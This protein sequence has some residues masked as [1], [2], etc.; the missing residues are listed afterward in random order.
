MKLMKWLKDMIFWKKSIKNPNISCPLEIMDITSRELSRTVQETSEV[1]RKLVKKLEDIEDQLEDREQLLDRMFHTIPDFLLLKDGKGHWL[2]LNAYGKKLYGITGRAYKG[3][4]DREIAETLSPRYKE[5]LLQCLKTDE[6]AWA[7]RKPTE[8]E[9]KSVDVFGREYIFDVV[10]TPLFNEDGSRKY[11]LV[12][13]RNITEEVNN[14]KH[15]GMLIRALDH[16][17]DSIVVTDH[18]HRIVYANKAFL[19]V[20]GYEL[21]DIL[22]KPASICASGDT[23]PLTFQ[24]MNDT[25]IRGDPWTGVVYNKRAN[26]RVVQ[27]LLTITPVL[28]GKPHPIYYIGVKR[29]IERRKVD[30]T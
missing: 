13:G 14:D 2:M 3:K 9:E 10:K 29:L 20:Y 4:S 21:E 8:F 6:E 7:N 15:I 28:N 30:R 1:S 26:G 19:K 16:A 27:E 5:N 22:M 25:I 12:H 11:L 17:S 23:D 18:E 24:L